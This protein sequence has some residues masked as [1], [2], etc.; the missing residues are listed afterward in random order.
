MHE[1]ILNVAGQVLGVVIQ[2][3]A[4]K[5]K[6][7]TMLIAKYVEMATKL[8]GTYGCSRHNGVADFL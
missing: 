7:G 6:K 3:T 5:W 1:L 8:L 2:L 4:D